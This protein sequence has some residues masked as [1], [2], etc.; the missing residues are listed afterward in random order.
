MVQTLDGM[1]AKSST[2]ARQVAIGTLMNTC[3]IGE[4][5]QDHC[6]KMKGHISTVEVMEAM[7]EQEMKGHMILKSLPYSFNQLKMNYNMNKLKFT[8]VDLMH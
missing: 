3:I 1:F 2:T 7:L 4:S 6:L 8:P 5:V